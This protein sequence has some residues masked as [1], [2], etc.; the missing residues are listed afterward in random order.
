MISWFQ[1]TFNKWDTIIQKGALEPEQSPKFQELASR[2]IKH[3]VITEEAEDSLPQVAEK[4]YI[5]KDRTHE[6]INKNIDLSGQIRANVDTEN[7]VSVL[8]GEINGNISKIHDIESQIRELE[9]RQL[10]LR[11]RSGN[12]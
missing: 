6:L 8:Q 11:K 3:N 1:S 12:L 5:L 2:Q 10:E 4:L 9:D 7:D